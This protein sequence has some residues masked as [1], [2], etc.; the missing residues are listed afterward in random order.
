MGTSNTKVNSRQI[1]TVGSSNSEFSLSGLI[2]KL[3]FRSFTS[4][5]SVRT[6]CSV[7]RPWPRIS[8][9]G[10]RESTLNNPLESIKT[11]WPVPLIEAIFLPNFKVSSDITKSYKIISPVAKGA[12]GNVYKVWK[13]DTHQYYAMK[14]LSKSKIL[15]ESCVAQ[16]KDEVKIQTICGHHPFIIDSPQYWQDRGRL[17]IVSNFVD[18]GDLFNLMEKYGALPEDI[19]RLYV[20]ELASALDF[21][22]NAGVIYRDLKA[23]NVLLDSN[24]HAVVVDFG[25]SKW[26]RYG[27]R[28]STICGTLNYMAPEVFSLQGYG[29]AVDWWSLGILTYFLIT[30]KEI[31][32]EREV[33]IK[34]GHNL[35][36]LNWKKKKEVCTTFESRTLISE[37]GSAKKRERTKISVAAVNRIE[38]KEE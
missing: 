2:G 21:L 10:W 4:G 30:N 25:L 3:S 32:R 31:M 1:S 14:I 7:S 17:Y 22:H 37:S 38:R 9:R 24:M 8:R 19:V 27:E 29:H 26:L 16:V 5:N 35:L 36:Q 18:G 13:E 20:A 12:F 34:G 28:T 33:C 6:T 15:N 23:E 11:A